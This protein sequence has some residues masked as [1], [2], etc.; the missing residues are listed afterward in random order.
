MLVDLRVWLAMRKQAGPVRQRAEMRG[1]GAHGGACDPFWG[2]GKWSWWVMRAVGRQGG[3]H[4]SLFSRG[5]DAHFARRFY[6]CAEG[7]PAP[8]LWPPFKVE[9]HAG[10]SEGRCRRGHVSRLRSAWAERGPRSPRPLRRAG[11]QATVRVTV[12]TGTWGFGLTQPA[13]LSDAGVSD[14]RL[15]RPQ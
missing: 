9:R 10:L 5:A 11:K 6:G 13:Q 2:V 1:D 4:F 7:S 12:S 3:P 15:S 8:I 14:V